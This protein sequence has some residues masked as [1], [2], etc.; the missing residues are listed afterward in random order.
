V[1]SR[2]CGHDAGVL[3]AIYDQEEVA[4]LEGHLPAGKV[5]Y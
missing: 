5:L 4:F 3:A 1:T 2:A